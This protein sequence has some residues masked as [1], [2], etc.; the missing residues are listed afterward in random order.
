VTRWE[1]NANGRLAQA[2]LE[3]FDERGFEQTTVEDIATRAGLTKRTFFRHFADKREVLFGGGSEFQDVFVAALAAAPA[4]AAPIEAVGASLEAA[5][6]VL[7]GRRAFALRRRRVIAATPE[8]QERELVKMASIAAALAAGL[9]ERGVAEPEAS[10]TAEAG[11]AVFR[12]AF[13]RWAADE[14]ADAQDLPA[15]VREAMGALG[16]VAAAR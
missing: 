12:V 13:E 2:A 14:G 10:V 4:S 8:L 16:A 11:V 3:L 7:Q 6:A 15:R 5:G 9:R 1:P